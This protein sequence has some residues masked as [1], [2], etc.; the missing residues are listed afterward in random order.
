MSTPPGAPGGPAVPRHPGIGNPATALDI[1]EHF[2]SGGRNIENQDVGRRHSTA[3]GFWQFLDSTWREWARKVPGASQYARAWLAP[4]EIQRQV[5]EKLYQAEGFAPWTADPRSQLRPFLAEH[6]GF[7]VG[8]S[9]HVVR[10]VIL[11]QH[12]VNHIHTD[13][14]DTGKRISLVHE[15]AAGDAVRTLRGRF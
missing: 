15:R 9:R 11:H 10:D 14:T 5:A 13:S 1:I 8:A 4:R 3:S 6:P 2:E 12:I 7:P